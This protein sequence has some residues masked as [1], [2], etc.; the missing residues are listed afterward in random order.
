MWL[1]IHIEI[2]ERGQIKKAQ[3]NRL[4]WIISSNLESIC[5]IEWINALQS[6]GFR[7]LYLILDIQSLR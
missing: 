5:R 2:D 3:E 1:Q 4:I 6:C 7:D